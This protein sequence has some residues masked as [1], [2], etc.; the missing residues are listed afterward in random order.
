MAP[1]PPSRSGGA[2]PTAASTAMT[3][4]VA[5]A[6]GSVGRGGNRGRIWQRRLPPPPLFSIPPVAVVASATAADGSGGGGDDQGDL[7]SA[8]WTDPVVATALVASRS[9]ASGAKNYSPLGGGLLISG[10]QRELRRDGWIGLAVFSSGR[11]WGVAGHPAPAAC[12]TASG[13][14]PPIPGDVNTAGTFGVQVTFGGFRYGC[15][16]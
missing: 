1:S 11:I 3:V 4:S 15:Y 6:G 14:G 9:R 16:G 5:S 10:M 13:A 7:T 2:V 12:L 8:P